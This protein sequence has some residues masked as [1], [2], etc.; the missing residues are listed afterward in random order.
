MIKVDQ[1]ILMRFQELIQ[2]GQKI[3]NTREKGYTKPEPGAYRSYY[4][5]I[6][7]QLAGQWGVSCL[8]LI[9]RVFNK[10]SDHYKKFDSLYADF[11]KPLA[12]PTV[13]THA[14]G[15]LVAAKD[16]YEHGYLFETRALI[17]AE[18]FDDFLEQARHLLDN[19]YYG[20]AAVVAGSV[21][22]DGL[23]KH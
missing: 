4:D 15:I 23:R 17:E 13:V 6:D 10:D 18:V 12:G 19:K 14:F 7:I 16:D 11:I 21:L 5:K 9:G 20:P 22:E 2:L 8:N 3:L 1:K